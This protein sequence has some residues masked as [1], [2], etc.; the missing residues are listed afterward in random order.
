[1]VYTVIHIAIY[2]KVILKLTIAQDGLEL[3]V[4]FL[5]QLPECWNYRYELPHPLYNIHTLESLTRLNPF[6][7]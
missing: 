3:V 6:K 4:I 2:T 5:P 1:M 7:C